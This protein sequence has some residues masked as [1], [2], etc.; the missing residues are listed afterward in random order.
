MPKMRETHSLLTMVEA[1]ELVGQNKGQSW[2]AHELSY[3]P[4]KELQAVI[5]ALAAQDAPA[6]DDWWWSYCVDE[7]VGNLQRIRDY[8]LKT[9][10][11]VPTIR[12]L[13]K[14]GTEDRTEDPIYNRLLLS[15]E[16]DKQAE[17]HKFVSVFGGPGDLSLDLWY[18]CLD[19]MNYLSIEG[20]E[21]T[22][23]FSALGNLFPE[24]RGQAA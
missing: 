6:I 17:V 16:E 22:R 13:Y 3:A 21:N 20:L 10:S 15:F 19:L 18:A 11:K 7:L 23:V 4:C 12:K 24:E 8:T 5:D 9:S 1:R 14:L 2:Y